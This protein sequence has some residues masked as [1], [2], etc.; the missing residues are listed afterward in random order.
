V[1]L[2]KRIE[3]VDL[4]ISLCL[5]I[6]QVRLLRGRKLEERLVQCGRLLVIPAIPC[7]F[8]AS[9]QDVKALSST[10][11]IDV[12]YHQSHKSVSADCL[13][14][15]LFLQAAMNWNRDVQPIFIEPWYRTTS[16]R[17]QLPSRSQRNRVV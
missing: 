3:E 2:I 8:L 1:D 17:H 9:C 4:L 12:L 10:I 5:N 14:S 15:E 7:F 13:S 6:L 11:S 16:N